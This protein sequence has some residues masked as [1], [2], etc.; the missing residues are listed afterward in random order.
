M[1]PPP[2]RG[3]CLMVWSD[4]P[5]SSD[6]EATDLPAASRSSTL[7]RTRVNIDKA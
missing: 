1:Y 5:R 7:R 2:L 4:T 6:K 3:V